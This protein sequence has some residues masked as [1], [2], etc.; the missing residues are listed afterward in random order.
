MFMVEII[1]HWK[2]SP[3]SQF[4]EG[5]LLELFS[6]VKLWKP[7]QSFQWKGQSRFYVFT[8]SRTHVSH[9]IVFLHLTILFLYY[10]FSFKSHSL[11]NKL[12]LVNLATGSFNSYTLS[13]DQTFG[14]DQSIK[15]CLLQEK[16]G[17]LWLFFH[18]PNSL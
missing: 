6:K 15:I 16:R 11:N 8:H 14:P 12:S 4:D 13:N 2:I 7:F 5:E 17:L 3:E 1:F 18:T 10:F 9:K